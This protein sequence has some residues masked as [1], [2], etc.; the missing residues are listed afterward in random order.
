MSEILRATLQKEI[1]SGML[2]QFQTELKVLCLVQRGLILSDTPSVCIGEETCIS[3]NTF[4][5]GLYHE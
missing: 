1:H 5:G 3:T 2:L 4:Q